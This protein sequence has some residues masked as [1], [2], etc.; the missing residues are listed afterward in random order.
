MGALCLSCLSLG[1]VTSPLVTLGSWTLASWMKPSSAASVTASFV[2]KI[3]FNV[4][5][6]LPVRMSVLHR[7][8]SYL[9]K[10][11]EGV[12]YPSLELQISLS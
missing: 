9:G 4:C 5:S 6:V 2:F 11:E 1:Q 12:R 3:I 8:V 7:Y 10:P